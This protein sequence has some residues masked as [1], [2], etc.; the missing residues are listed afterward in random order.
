MPRL[1]KFQSTRGI[2]SCGAPAC[3]EPKVYGHFLCNEHLEEIL[4]IKNLFDKDTEERARSA[5]GRKN[6][7]RR[8]YAKTPT[9]C[10]T[11]CTE[12]RIPPNSYCDFHEEEAEILE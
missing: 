3:D 7:N 6:G 1:P 10:W 5:L 9:C 11:G 8:S 2:G 4:K 12:P